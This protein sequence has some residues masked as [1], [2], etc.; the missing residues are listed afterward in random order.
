[1]YFTNNHVSIEI[2][3]LPDDDLESAPE[4][5]LFALLLYHRWLIRTAMQ[6]VFLNGPA[7]ISRY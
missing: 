2:P 4:A 1:M 5:Y 7:R 6:G 3:N